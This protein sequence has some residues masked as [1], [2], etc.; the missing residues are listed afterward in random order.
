MIPQQPADEAREQRI[1]MEIVVDAYDAEEQ[2]SGWYNYLS[3]TLH[4]PFLARCIA[5]RATSP[6]RVGYL[7]QEHGDDPVAGQG[8]ARTAL[9]TFRE[10]VVM[11]EDE[12]RAFL[13]KFLIGGDEVHRRLDELSYGERAKLAL[14]TLVASGANL[15]LLDEP[16]SHLDVAALERIEGALAAYPGPLVVASHDRYFLGA[17]GVTGVLLLEDGRLR[18]L[19][20]L[21]AYEEEALAGRS[22]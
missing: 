3:D 18:R 16:T 7:P 13:D 2:A 10:G 1:Q 8:S 12:A 5:E 14:A 22:A 21:A 6:L 19:P 17:I 15:L 9:Q 20:G 4:F 11:H